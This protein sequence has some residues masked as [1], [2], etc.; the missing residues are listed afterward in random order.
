MAK[1]KDVL[2]FVRLAEELRTK[3]KESFIETKGYIK[4]LL[5]QQNETAKKCKNVQA[6]M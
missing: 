5:H 6:V 4:G 3:N 2:E 1:D